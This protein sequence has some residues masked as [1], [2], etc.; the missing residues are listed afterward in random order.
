MR[1]QQVV[2][3]FK[4][5]KL[6]APDVVRRFQQKSRFGIRKP[7]FYPLNYGNNDIYDFRFSLGDCNQRRTL[8][9]CATRSV[10][11]PPEL[12][13][14]FFCSEKIQERF[15]GRRR[16]GGIL[17]GDQSTVHNGKRLPVT[18]FFKNCSQA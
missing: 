17:P 6:S 15:G 4:Y 2:N 14:R 5:S 11:W 1:R 9:V 10:T 7:L 3:D 8:R 16:R 18:H 13:G 12:L